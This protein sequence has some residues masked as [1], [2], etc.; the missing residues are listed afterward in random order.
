MN[1]NDFKNP[2]IQS[3]AV[4]LFVFLLISIVAASGS[5][6]VWGSIGALFSGLISGIIFLIAL[7]LAIIV[8]IALIIGLFIAAVSIYSVD[9]GKEMWGQ[10]TNSI[11]VLFQKITGSGKSIAFT[12]SPATETSASASGQ[13]TQAEPDVNAERFVSLEAKLSSLVEKLSDLKQLSAHQA[14]TIDQLKQQIADI[15]N[16]DSFDAKFA[17]MTVSHQTLETRIE[18]I[19]GELVSGEGARQQFEKQ[20]TDEIGSIQEELKALHEK[21]S[22]PE[23][24]SGVLSYIDLPED[25]DLVTDKAKEAISRGM[26]YSQIDEFFKDSLKPEVYEE[27][28][29]HP[30]LTKD[31]LRSIKK[32]F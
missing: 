8:S 31:F 4:L 9:K 2:L 3:G 32:K 6:G 15:A 21:T 27:L 25:R 7:F 12:S 1:K 11:G 22:V 23:A 13:S 29:S 30:R 14:E 20:F 17:D 18:E 16:S 24:I 28:A 26:T 19:S 5:Q 10:F